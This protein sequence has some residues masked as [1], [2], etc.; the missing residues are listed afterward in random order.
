VERAQEL[1]TESL[2][3]I[4]AAYEAGVT[5]RPWSEFQIGMIHTLL[6]Q[7][8][9]AL[10]WLEE[11]QASGLNW[12]AL[13]LQEAAIDPHRG[14]PPVRADPGARS[15]RG[16]PHAGERVGRAGGKAGG[17]SQAA[18]GWPVPLA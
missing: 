14:N 16:R 18:A 2:T 3:E 10:D 13:W 11:S 5:P 1:L 6:G 17:V 15:R 8:D 12:E 4:V 9:Q 7:H